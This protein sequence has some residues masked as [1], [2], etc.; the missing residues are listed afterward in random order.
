[1]YFAR[2]DYTAK[3]ATT[4][5]DLDRIYRKAIRVILAAGFRKMINLG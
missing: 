4:R 5:I 1:M 3:S 2:T